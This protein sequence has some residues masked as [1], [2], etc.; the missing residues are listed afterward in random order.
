MGLEVITRFERKFQKQKNDD[1]ASTVESHVVLP[2][3]K[4]VEKKNT[5]SI[6]KK[7]GRGGSFITALEKERKLR[8]KVFENGG[9]IP[10]SSKMDAASTI[11]YLSSHG[12]YNPH[13]KD[14]KNITGKRTLIR[15]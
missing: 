11:F 8:T 1:L 5:G 10:L 6:G 2:R 3:E 9:G 15:T 7:K 13:I 12:S 14:S 4:R